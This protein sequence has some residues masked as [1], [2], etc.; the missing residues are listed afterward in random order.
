MCHVYVSVYV[1][2][3]GM[4]IL[5]DWVCVFVEKRPQGNLSFTRLTKVEAGAENILCHI[6]LWFVS[7]TNQ[8]VKEIPNQNSGNCFGTASP[9]I[10]KNRNPGKPGFS[11]ETGL[12][13][14]SVS[15]P[16]PS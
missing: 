4:C 11:G 2:R 1:L 12:Q 14:G 6:S 5:C 10:G 13:S 8:H 16:W 15:Q 7:P 9:K 3:M